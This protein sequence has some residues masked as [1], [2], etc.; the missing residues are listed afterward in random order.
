MKV[1]VT[2]GTGFIGQYVLRKLSG[3][4]SIRCLVRKTSDISVPKETGAEIVVGDVT[5]RVSVKNAMSGMEAVI[6]LANIY[7][8][9]IPRRKDYYAVN[10]EGTRNVMEEA[11]DAG[12]K[13]VVHISTEVVYG[14]PEDSPYSEESTPSKKRFSLYAETKYMGDQVAWALHKEKSL[15]LVVVYPA[16]VLGRGDTRPSGRY[17]D[18]LA[19]RKMPTQVFVNTVLTFVH[20]NDVAEI[21]VRALEKEGNIG[22][23]YFAGTHRHSFAEINAFVSEAAGVPLPRIVMPTWL[24]TINAAVLTFLAGIFKFRPMLGMSNDQIRTMKIGFLADGSKAVRE[25]GIEYT[26]IKKAVEDAVSSK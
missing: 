15:P 17:V 1:L 26:P 6:H 24:A 10:V 21:I 16:A 2:G 13:K 23:K 4:H 19:T 11:L 20:V 25:L 3:K 14:A 8:F 22:E 9:W 7:D 18:A 12:V 5:D